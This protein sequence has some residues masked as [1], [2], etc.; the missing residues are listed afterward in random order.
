V[1]AF[2]LWTL[3]QPAQPTDNA[4]GDKAEAQGLGR[5]QTSAWWS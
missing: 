3:S 4:P 1:D 5:N 2:D